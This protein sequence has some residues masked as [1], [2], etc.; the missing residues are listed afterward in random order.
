MEFGSGLYLVEQADGLIVDWKLFREYPRPD[1]HCVQESIER[2]REKFGGVESYTADRGFWT[3]YNTEFLDTQGI[4]NGICP[5]DP[6]IMAD[7]QSDTQFAALQKRRAQ[8]EGR[9]A[10]LKNVFTGNP[11]NCS[12]FGHRQKAVAWC[13]LAHNLWS[14]ATMARKGKA[15]QEDPPIPIAA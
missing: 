12:G 13:V 10:I 5:K 15:Q 1:A 8:T 11:L 9:I 7:R 6:Q 14:L 2:V 3:K 4:T